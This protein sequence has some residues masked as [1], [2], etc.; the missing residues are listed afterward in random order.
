M[1]GA[2][3]LARFGTDDE[4]HSNRRTSLAIIP[5][6]EEDPTQ[7]DGHPTGN[8]G[9]RA[10]LSADCPIRYAHFPWRLVR[11]RASAR[12][13]A[14]GTS[15]TPAIIRWAG[16]A[17]IAVATPTAAAERIDYRTGEIRWSTPRYGAN[18]GLLT[19]AGNILFG[20]AASGI[21]AYNAATRELLWASRIGSVTNGPITDELDDLQYVVAGA[22]TRLV[23]FVLNE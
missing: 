10:C 20:P 3:R 1:Q 19:T 13:S 23:T 17:R 12:S 16:A 18:A 9:P 2:E 14:S 15:T 5:W 6:A 7:L 22:G 11:A 4:I 21:G 8:D